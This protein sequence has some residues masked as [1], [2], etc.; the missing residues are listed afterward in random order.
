[1]PDRSWHGEHAANVVASPEAGKTWAA[2]KSAKQ[3]AGFK[4][5][6]R[7]TRSGRVVE[8]P[9]TEDEERPVDEE[10]SLLPDQEEYGNGNHGKGAT[11]A[12]GTGAGVAR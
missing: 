3:R 8:M 7:R 1:M 6:H 2:G 9:V 10:T 12:T 11:R 4:K 5:Y